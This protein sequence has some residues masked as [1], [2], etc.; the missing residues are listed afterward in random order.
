MRRVTQVLSVGQDR[1]GRRESVPYFV[2]LQR[3]G[4]R[5]AEEQSMDA[6]IRIVSPDDHVVEPAHLWSARLPQRYKDIGPTIERTRG[7][8][9]GEDFEQDDDGAAADV[10]LYEGR[11]A[12]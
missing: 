11:A 5:V 4:A 6:A 12:A 8:M 10:W 9:R 2:K 1:A 3:L 7:F